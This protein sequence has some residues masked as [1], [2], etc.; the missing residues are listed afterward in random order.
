MKSML[1]FAAALVSVLLV[2][3]ARHHSPTRRKIARIW[4]GRVSWEDTEVNT[5]M[6]RPANTT[7]LRPVN[8]TMLRSTTFNEAQSD[9]SIS[10]CA[11]HVMFTTFKCPRCDSLR[12]RI[13][14]N[15]YHTWSTMEGVTFEVIS[16]SNT[17]EHGVP[18]LGDMFLKMMS[19]CPNAASYT[20]INGDII[21]RE[22]MVETLEVVRTLGDFLMVGR[23]T[24]VA[25]SESS[26]FDSAHPDFDFDSHFE[27]G[28]LFRTDAQDYFSV[29]RN[30]IDWNAI[31]PFVIGRP[32]YDNWLVDHIYHNPKVALVDATQTVAVIHQTD[33][34][35]NS[36]HGGSMARSKEDTQYNRRIGK[37]QWD[38]GRTSHAEWETDRRSGKIVVQ[39]RNK[40]GTGFYFPNG[41]K[42][43]YVSTW[44]DNKNIES[45]EFIVGLQEKLDL[46]FPLTL[47]AFSGFDVEGQ[48]SKMKELTNRGIG[49]RIE[50]HTTNHHKDGDKWNQKHV[51]NSVEEYIG[52]QKWIRTTFG[53]EH[54]SI[55]SYPHGA[56]P[57]T[58][59]TIRRIKS[60]YLAARTT[61][62][63]LF[64][65][66]SQNEM[67]MPCTAIES[68]SK[69]SLF[70][71]MKKSGVMITYGHG[72][73]GISGW[74]PVD[75]GKLRQHFEDLKA[76]RDDIWFTTLDNVMT[77][78][79]MTLQIPGKVVDACSADETPETA[80]FKHQKDELV[81]SVAKMD[82]KT[83]KDLKTRATDAENKMVGN[84][85]VVNDVLLNSLGGVGSS[86][87]IKE[88]ER[89]TVK[90]NDPG[91]KDGFKHRNSDYFQWT[92]DGIYGLSEQ[93]VLT[94]FNKIIIVIGEPIHSILS[95]YRRFKVDH[96]NK[97]RRNVHRTQFDKDFDINK[98]WNM[99]LAAKGD[100]L[101]IQEYLQSWLVK[102]KEY[103]SICQVVDTETLYNHADYYAKYAGVK[104]VARFKA[105]SYQPTSTRRPNT[106]ENIPSGVLHIYKTLYAT[107]YEDMQH[108]IRNISELNDKLNIPSPNIQKRPEDK[109]TTNAA[110]FPN[111]VFIKSVKVGGSTF[112]GVL[113]RVAHR[114]HLSGVNN[115][116]WITREPGIWANHGRI[117]EMTPKISELKKETILL[118]M[119]RNPTDQMFSAFYHFEVSRKHKS[120]SDENIIS[121][122]GTRRNVQTNYIGRQLN[123][124][125]LVVVTERFNECMV[126]LK[127]MFNCSFA[128]LLYV[129]SK[130]SRVLQYDDTGA[131]FTPRK[132]F[133]EM[134][135][136]VQEYI[137]TT[138]TVKNA[139]DFALW[140]TA[141]KQLDDHIQKYTDFRRDLQYFETHLEQATKKCAF[142]YTDCYWNDNDC[143]I[144]CLNQYAMQ[145]MT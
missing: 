71:A 40:K 65:D 73:R 79:R 23:R 57:S 116:A 30:A 13:E 4:H 135:D 80:A 107:A 142:D 61:K 124:Y 119:V 91:D 45:L 55:L 47:F 114:Y 82:K 43:A 145:H 5:T 115:D 101:G 51:R 34:D 68:I 97:W 11:S 108:H 102:C 138:W 37:G 130:N 84:E 144:K 1:V 74:N 105:M 22:D 92:S 137:R 118:A 53:C 19:K 66:A 111:I 52:N 72:V 112:A 64:V 17:N 106:D 69:A 90:S 76:N 38:H 39:N 96:L 48:V 35:G 75:P 85:K 49:D 9:D 24:N 110:S 6:L 123:D 127:H 14:N 25:W 98:I 56:P 86:N 60:A 103:R 126:I 122:A 104:N 32:G 59:E 113:R 10:G 134:S 128:D 33:H 136:T 46:K 133:D 21:G 141:N 129:R 31:P 117:Y 89:T 62:Q 132:R 88:I 7:M 95:V 15:T 54:G 120:D 27:N 140:N 36:A 26:E 44:D 2:F 3:A 143:S 99:T 67:M 18:I 50:C 81:K 100:V 93:G 41:K 63:G 12:E 42:M 16:V 94:K 83:R 20:Y 131:A 58:S 139:D 28:A 125:N 87:F 8:T 78:L 121:F 77:F 109:L 70:N 29:T